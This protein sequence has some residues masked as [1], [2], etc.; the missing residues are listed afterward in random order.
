[1]KGLPLEDRKANGKLFE[2]GTEAK[3]RATETLVWIFIF[4][5]A[6]PYFILCKGLPLEDRKVD[7]IIFLT[8]IQRPRPGQ[9]RLWSPCNTSPKLGL[10][11]AQLTIVYKAST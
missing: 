2:G 3:T 6:R 8:G 9:Q 4:E 1:M 10:T 7:G 5:R 11:G